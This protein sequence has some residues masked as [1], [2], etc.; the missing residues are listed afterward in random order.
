MYESYYRMKTRAFENTADS[1]LFFQSPQ[2][3]EAWYF[4][5]QGIT[6]REQ[7]LLVIGDYGV[8]KTTLCAKLV[9]ALK[10]NGIAPLAASP[11][12]SYQGL[13]KQILTF[14]LPDSTITEVGPAH[15]ALI[16]YFEAQQQIRPLYVIID[17]AHEMDVP[18]LSK[19]FSLAKCTRNGTPPLRL[20]L[21]A[22]SNFVQMLKWP[23]LEP[24]NQRIRMRFRLNPLDAEQT[25]EYIYFR[26]VN[27]GATGVPFFEPAAIE[28]IFK[29]SQGVPRMINNVCEFCLMLGATGNQT[30]IDTSEVERAAAYLSPP[31]PAPPA[32]TA[33]STGTDT[34]E[35]TGIAP[36]QAEPHPRRVTIKLTDAAD[37]DADLAATDEVDLLQTDELVRAVKVKPAEPKS[38]TVFILIIVVLL[39]ALLASL[40]L[41]F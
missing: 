30:V 5:V 21:F 16:E 38:M 41:R 6:A 13:L 19:L 10:K 27:A 33:P 40:Y 22:H 9:S 17:D 39:L 11:I 32:P 28:R 7:F 36:Q 12:A 34:R 24:L 3:K 35:A 37:A 1:E 14:Y 23:D 29:F 4:L 20:L 15:D 8:G 25:K 26:L 2:H 18:T 31:A